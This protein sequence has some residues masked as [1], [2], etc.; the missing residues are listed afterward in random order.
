MFRNILDEKEFLDNKKIDFTYT[1]VAIWIS[2]NPG[3]LLVKNHCFWVKQ[4]RKKGFLM[5]YI[6]K[7]PKYR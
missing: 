3:M 5:F 2:S 4:P 1:V 6:D 7:K